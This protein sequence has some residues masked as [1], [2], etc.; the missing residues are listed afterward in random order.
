MN[1]NQKL[2]QDWKKGKKEKKL[3]QDWKKQKQREEKLRTSYLKRIA[4]LFN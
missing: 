1:Q 4:Y 3:Y 2:Y